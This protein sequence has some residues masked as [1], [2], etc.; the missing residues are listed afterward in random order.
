[1]LAN[2]KLAAY[3]SIPFAAAVVASLTLVGCNNKPPAEQVVPVPQT[4]TYNPGAITPAAAPKAKQEHDVFD[5]EAA[6]ALLK[7]QC[8]M[9]PRPLGSEA[10]EKCLTLLLGEMRKYADDTISQKFTYKSGD[11]RLVNT[12]IIGIFNPAGSKAP[13]THPILLMTHWDTRPIA[14]GPFSDQI[15]KRNIDFR[16]SNG[17]WNP[18]TPILG[19]SDAAS[20]VGVLL[21][22]AKMFKAH[23]PACG[24]IILLDDGEDY[25]DFRANNNEGDGVELG[26]RYFAEHYKEEPK[27]GQPTFGIL[28]DM[29]GGTNAFFPREELSD[30]GD[31][32]TY[33]DMFYA[34]AKELNYESTFPADQ[35]QSVGD[36]HVWTNKHGIP[37]IDIIQP[38]PYGDYVNKGYTSWHTLQDTPAKCSAKTLKKV[39]DVV[40]GVIYDIAP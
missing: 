16:F 11:Q 31:A 36:D 12:N 25:G 34:K 1:M 38:L 40:S 14:D 30:T 24:V 32:K 7:Q 28:L 22:L 20:G 19:A 9:G 39:G 29:V 35:K 6:F 33:N 8:D 18:Q 5:G 26:A 27:F 2:T 23:P 37:T 21:E 3:F 17:K 10:H 13:S 4:L 15:T